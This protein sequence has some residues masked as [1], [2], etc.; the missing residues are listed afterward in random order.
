L[1]LAAVK[2]NLEGGCVGTGKRKG[3]EGGRVEGKSFKPATRIRSL[4]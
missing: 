2:G 1:H 3:D 4:A